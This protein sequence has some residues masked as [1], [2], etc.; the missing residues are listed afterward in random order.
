[1]VNNE[2]KRTEPLLVDRKSVVNVPHRTYLLE[3]H[4]FLKLTKIPSYL[5]IWAHSFFAGTGIFIFTILARWVDHRFFDGQSS[6]ATWEWILL[7]MLAAL[8]LVLEGL[9]YWLPSEKKKTAV[10]I[11]AFFD[12]EGD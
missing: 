5:A 1:M 8:V 6:I 10:N 3:Y 4:D 2:T 12:G 7:A 9:V 11:Q